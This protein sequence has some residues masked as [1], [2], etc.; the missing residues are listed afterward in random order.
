MTHGSRYVH[1]FPCLNC[2]VRCSILKELLLD[3]PRWVAWAITGSSM[4]MLWANVAVTPPNG[5]ALIMHHRQLNLDHKVSMGVVQVAWE[6]LKAQA[7]TW[8]PALPNE[9]FWQSP[10]Q[11]A[12]LAYL[13]QE[14]RY[15]RTASTAVELVE[16]TMTQKLIPEVLADLRIVLQVLGKPIDQLRTLRELLDPAA[17]VEAGKLAPAFEA[18]L[19]SFTTK[20][21]GRLYL[22]NPL[23]AR[24]IHAV[25]TESGELVESINT[26]QQWNSPTMFRELI[27]LGERCKERGKLYQSFKDLHILLEDMASALALTPDRLVAEDWFIHV[28]DHRC[29]SQGSKANFKKN[30]RAQAQQDAK[31]GLRRFYVLLCNVL[32]HGNIV[33]QQEALEFYPPE[34]ARFHSSGRISEVVTKVCS[35]PMFRMYDSPMPRRSKAP[36]TSAAASPRAQLQPHMGPRRP[37]LLHLGKQLGRASIIQPRYMGRM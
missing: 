29:N 21:A 34:L 7:A 30:Y 6:Q 12:M 37:I 27:V 3:S 24:V 14:W 8:D 10:P 15:R 28:L 20:R 18:L 22:D 35:S 13:C 33:E 11:I 5:F 1:H 9:L 23:F 36:A 4:A 2:R 17:G 31:V 19:G 26:V 25:T 32:C 16:Q